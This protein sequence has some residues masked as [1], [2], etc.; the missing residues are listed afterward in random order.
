LYDTAV[1]PGETKNL[2][3]THPDR[4][5]DLERRL[6]AHYKAIG[7]DLAARKWETGFNPVYTFPAKPSPRDE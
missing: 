2:A 4:A 5:D 3:A 6:F 1:D 7:H